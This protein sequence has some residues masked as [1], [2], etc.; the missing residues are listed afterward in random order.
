[1]GLGRGSGG[2]KPADGKRISEFKIPLEGGA[3]L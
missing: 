3:P 2:A 1:M